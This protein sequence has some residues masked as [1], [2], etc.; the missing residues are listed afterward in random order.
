MHAG[1]IEVEGPRWLERLF[2]SWGGAVT[3]PPVAGIEGPTVRQGTPV[4]R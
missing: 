3:Y 4:A 1:Q 2:A